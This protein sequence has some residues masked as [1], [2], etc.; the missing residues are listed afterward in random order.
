MKIRESIGLAYT[1]I[2]LLAMTDGSCSAHAVEIRFDG[3]PEDSMSQLS[4]LALS[5]IVDPPGLGLIRVQA[6][7]QIISAVATQEK[8]TARIPLVD[9]LNVVTVLYGG[10]SRSLVVTLAKRLD[11]RPPQSVRIVWDSNADEQIRSIAT[12]TTVGVHSML[13]LDDFVRRVKDGMRDVLLRAYAQIA[14]ITIVA[15]DG[16]DVYTIEVTSSD[17]LD[18]SYGITPPPIDCGNRNLKGASRISLALFR[19]QMRDHLDREW[20]PMLRADPLELRAQDVAEALGRTAAH[21][22]GHA[23]GLVSDSNSNSCGWM[24]GCDKGHNCAAFQ[25]EHPGVARFGSGTSIMDPGSS[26]RNHLRIAEPLERG[27]S[28]R[29]PAKFDKISRGYLSMIE[30]IP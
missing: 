17:L 29:A 21:E 15:H 8:W 13:E 3:D 18:G 12:E 16:D 5:G 30:P 26:T 22:L 14:N 28:V 20:K 2:L 4:E 23:L 27:R 19:Q 25:Q 7:A 24:N 1:L 9:G 10:I 11:S 6:G